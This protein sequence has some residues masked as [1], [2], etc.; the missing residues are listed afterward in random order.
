MQTAVQ[1][2]EQ[3]RSEF[4]SIPIALSVISVMEL[5]HGIERADVDLRRQR[6][7]AFV[8]DLISDFVVYP[9]TMEIAQRAGRLAAR[10]AIAGTVI[11]S[12]DLLIGAT[13]IHY[14]F[15]VL[16]DNISTSR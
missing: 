8:N 14:R 10:R 12:E 11:P 4:G 15:G 3:I 9:V 5:T 1:L 16:T 13:A 2:L 6:R 7:Q